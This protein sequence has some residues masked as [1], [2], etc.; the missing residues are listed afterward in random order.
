MKIGRVFPTRTSFSPSDEDAYFDVPDMFT[1]QY[2][3]VHISCTFT[4]DKK[5][6]EHL[7][8]QWQDYGKIKLGGVAYDDPGTIFNSGIYIKKGC[9]FTSRGCVRQC[10]EGH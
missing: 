6:A 7:A 2:D 5:K 4:W 3:E 9:V 8:Y 10:R 1:P